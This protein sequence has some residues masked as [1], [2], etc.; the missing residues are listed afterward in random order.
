V[1]HTRPECPELV[2]GW[3]TG[4]ATGI[5]RIHRRPID[6]SPPVVSLVIPTRHEARTIAGFI[7][8]TVRAL[9]AV[10]AEI[11]V[12]DDSDLDNTLKVLREAR[13]RIGDRLVALHRARGSVPERTL[14]TA[15]VT[16]IRVAR[17]EFICVLDA[18]G[19]H[20]PEAIPTML[21]VARDTGADYVGGS[22]YAPGGS[23]EGL[24]G[25]A[26]RAISRGLALLTRLA[27]SPTPIRT[28]SDPLTGFFVFRREIVEGVDLVPVGWK[29]SL[30]VLVRSGVRRLAEVPYV[31]AR[32]AGG[33]SK[34]TLWQGVLVLRHIL[35]LATSGAEGPR[36]RRAPRP[37][38]VPM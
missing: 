35:A 17:G 22:R 20:P 31:F 4:G 16:G 14:G 37:P 12:V 21:Q 30:E 1:P 9:G 19:Q 15:V 29:I 10:P 25:A 5:G 13:E 36:R 23:A 24:E 27:F 2:E 38:R 7:E 18:D 26:R 32:R 8:R 6:L 33:D 3:T 28:L 34:A 11:I